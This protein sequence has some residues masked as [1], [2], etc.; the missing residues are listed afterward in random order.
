MISRNKIFHEVKYMLIAVVFAML[1]RSLF[2]EPYVVPSSSMK[3]NLLIGDY[4]FVSK[5]AYGYSRYSFPLGLN[6]FKGRFFF[7]EPKAGDIVVFKKPS[8]TSDA[9]VK[10]LIGL[11][12]DKIEIIDGQLLVNDQL[13]TYETL[14]AFDDGKMMDQ[15][16]EKHTRENKNYPILKIH[17]NDNFGPII[18]PPK[19]YFMLGDNRD[20][21]KDSRFMSA[22]GLIP[23]DYLV[24]K[25]EMIFYSTDAPS[26]W[27][28]WTWLAKVRPERLL[29]K[30]Q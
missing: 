12:G 19:M 16:L 1:F 6:I 21:S 5:F 3:P 14:D 15:F 26:F 27:Q 29:K 30:L 10:R 22:V 13:C 23:E 28:I 18:V 4:I 25:A 7:K 9:Y 24:G 20:N 17:F 8:D 2:Y 11:P